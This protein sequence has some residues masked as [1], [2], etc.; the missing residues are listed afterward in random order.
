MA[1][2]L[3]VFAIYGKDK[4]KVLYY[5]SLSTGKSSSQQ[6]RLSTIPLYSS[7]SRNW[8]GQFSLFLKNSFFLFFK[9]LK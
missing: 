9:V 3:I 4:G 2:S 6:A 5:L 8:R 7:L 1:F